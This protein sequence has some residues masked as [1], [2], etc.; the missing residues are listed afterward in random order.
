MADVK[1]VQ[2]MDLLNNAAGGAVV[3]PDFQ[4]DFVW[5]RKQIE[6]LLNSVINNYFIGSLLLLESSIDNL[7]FAPRLIRGVDQN[8]ASSQKHNTL[9]YVGSKH[10]NVRVIT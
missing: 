6:E 7:R 2:M 3:L 10:L 5:E 9:K 1:Q 8:V 4:R